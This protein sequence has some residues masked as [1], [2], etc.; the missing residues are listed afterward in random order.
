M[1]VLEKL[2]LDADPKRARILEGAMKVFLAYGF[3]RTTMDDIARAAEVSR[4]ALYLQF[5]N[6]TE[7]YRAL[8]AVICGRMVATWS[9]ELPSDAVFA[10]RV[11]RSFDASFIAMKREVEESPHGAELMDLGNRLAGD[12]IEEC[13]G[14]ISGLLAGAIARE[15]DIKGT[16]LSRRGLSAQHMA[17][18]MLDALDGLK[19]RRGDNDCQAATVKT[20]I[21]MVE[22]A[23]RP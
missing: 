6:K 15:A 22:Q 23:I 9:T 18:I 8:V 21:A 3:D 2:E 14:K 16:D 12:I 11:T 17:D 13:R 7:I 20:L 5:K 1:D 4:P 10:D 19:M